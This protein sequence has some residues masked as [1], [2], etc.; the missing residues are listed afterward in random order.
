MSLA[1]PDSLSS[2]SSTL[3]FGISA[4]MNSRVEFW[5]RFWISVRVRSIA[6]LLGSC[7]SFESGS[8]AR[9]GAVGA[10]GP[11]RRDYIPY[12]RAGATGVL[13]LHS[14]QPSPIRERELF[15]GLERAGPCG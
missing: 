5:S 2:I 7:R 10:V 8:S 4:S 11:C 9:F 14:C 13:R 12:L 6:S 3:D 15:G 1:K